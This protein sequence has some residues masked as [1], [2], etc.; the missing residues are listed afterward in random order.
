MPSLHE[1]V[2]KN[3][4]TLYG[5]YGFEWC[6]VLCYRCSVFSSWINRSS[7]EYSEPVGICN[8]WTWIQPYPDNLQQRN[9]SR[10]DSLETDADSY[11]AHFSS[12]VPVETKG[13]NMRFSKLPDFKNIE[14]I[15]KFQ[16]VVI[17]LCEIKRD[18]HEIF[19]SQNKGVF[20]F[21]AFVP[22]ER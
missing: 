9:F 5:C 17:L 21:T 6:Y 11:K 14:K 7:L 1:K 8:I 19:L 4:R 12:V 18:I 16:N 13:Y 15:M 22:T 10:D 3:D 20:I 2:A